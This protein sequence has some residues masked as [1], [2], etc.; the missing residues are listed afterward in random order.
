ELP[1]E[2]H[3]ATKLTVY[4][5]RADRVAGRPAHLAIVERLRAHGVAGA[6]VLLGVDGTVHGVRERAR[7]FSRNEAVPLMVVS[8][9]AGAAIAAVLAELSH[10]LPQPVATLERIRLCKRDGEL[11]ADPG[12]APEHDDSGRPL[13]QKLSVFCGEQARHRGHSLHLQ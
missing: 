8:V 3:E 9:G 7:F 1:E 6:T 2:L 11:L 10:L 5:G 12:Q 4:C 13:F